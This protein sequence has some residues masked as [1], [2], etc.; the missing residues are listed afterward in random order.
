MTNPASKPPLIPVNAVI[1]AGFPILALILVPLWGFYQG[2]SGAQWLWALVFLYLNGLSITAGYHRLWA[3]N[4]YDAHPALKW[5]FALWGAGALQNSILIWASDHRRHHRHVDDNERDPYSA[6]RG[7]WFSHM[8]WILRNYPSGDNDFSNARDLQRDPVVMF[9]H[10]HYVLL[11]TVMNLGLP[12]LL[13]WWLG[14][15]IGTVLLVGLLRLVVNHHFTFFINSLA[16]FWGSRPYTEEN[17]ARDNPV[18]AFLTYGEGYHN[19]HHLFQNDYRNGIRW[20]H[21]DPTKWL[22]SGCARVG[23]ASRLQRVPDFRIQRAILDTQFARARRALEAQEANEGL[24]SVLEREY[25]LFT[26]SVNQW[27]ALQAE[28]YDRKK[29]ELGD[30]LEAR[31]QQLLDRWEHAALRTRLQELEYSLKMQRKRLGLLLQQ[32]QLTPQPA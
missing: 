22:I 7:L 20:Y 14:D 21:W 11:T 13:G 31:R 18:L 15:I 32:V 10:R 29:S 17:S 23:L 26:E 4:A 25:Q 16:H 9:Q 1:F 27:K 28:R 5:F 24:R 6:G 12:V 30:A 19:Y 3:H 8:G 2:F